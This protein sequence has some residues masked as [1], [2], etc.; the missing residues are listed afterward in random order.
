MAALRLVQDRQLGLDEDV[1]LASELH[2]S[3]SLSS[4]GEELMFR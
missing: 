4:T 3:G 2:G 1:A